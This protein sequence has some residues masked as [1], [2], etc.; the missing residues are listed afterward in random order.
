MRKRAPELYLVPYGLSSH[1]KSIS[2]FHLFPYVAKFGV[3]SY[4]DFHT[5][6]V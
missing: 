3:L 6:V 4:E 2:V 1:L 5:Y